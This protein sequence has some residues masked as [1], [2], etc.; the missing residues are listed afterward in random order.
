MIPENMQLGE[1]ETMLLSAT[2][3]LLLVALLILKIRSNK[4]NF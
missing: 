3:I 1:T 2:V 4:R